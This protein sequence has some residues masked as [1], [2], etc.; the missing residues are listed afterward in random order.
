[1]IILTNTTVYINEILTALTSLIGA[2]AVFRIVY[3]LL[4]AKNNGDSIA[5][6]MEKCKRV[7]Y[8]AC[9]G[10]CASELLKILQKYFKVTNSSGPDKVAG[11]LVKI[12]NDM[13]T[14]FVAIEGVLVIYLMILEG[15]KYQAAEPD[16]KGIHKKNMKSILGV[17]ILV[18]SITTLVPVILGYFT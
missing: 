6:A 5:K 4:Q 15:I 18:V 1:M 7:L 16:E 17:G 2:G 14:V 13:V 11:Y 10:I 8:A 3:S 12:L 9:L